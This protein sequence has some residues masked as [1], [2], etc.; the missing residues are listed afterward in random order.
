MT[1]SVSASALSATLPDPEVAG[2]AAANSLRPWREQAPTLV[3]MN[4]VC[5]MTSLSRT[6]LNK[7]RAKGQ[8]PEPVPLGE[9]RFAFVRTE[10]EAWIAARI[11]SRS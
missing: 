2:Q 4:D 5:A 1:T 11:A 10:V 3:S 7:C 9:K 6:F 8:F